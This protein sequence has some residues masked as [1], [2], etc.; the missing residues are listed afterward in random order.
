MLNSF[1]RSL[2][3][4]SLPFRGRDRYMHGFDLAAPR[5]AEGFEDYLEPVTALCRAA[6]A[7]VGKAYMTVDEKIVQPG[8]SQRRPGPHVDG[9]FLPESASWGHDGGGGWNHICNNVPMARMPVIVAAS[10][11]GCRVWDGDFDA[12]PAPD[13]DLSH[14]VDRLG[15]GEI[16]PAGMGY[17]LSPDCVHE[18]MV[19]EAPTQRSFLR[20]ALPIAFGEAMRR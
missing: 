10:A 3:P 5:M 18:S 15:E 11:V 12:Q 4:V 17:L 2:V 9:Q 20:I 6:G 8:R 14:I 1:Y 16:V 13:G 7:L 19:F